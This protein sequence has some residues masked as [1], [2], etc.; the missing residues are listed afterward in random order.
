MTIVGVEFVLGHQ[1]Q[2][3]LLACLTQAG[4][5]R[6]IWDLTR[7]E[8]VDPLLKGHLRPA[9]EV[10]DLQDEIFRIELTDGLNLE[11]LLLEGRQRQY[12]AIVDATKLR[13]PMVDN[14]G[15]VA[16]VE[17]YNVDAIHL[18]DVLV[19]LP[20]VDVLGNEL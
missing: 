18:L 14:V 6:I 1:C 19:A 5:I 16:Q 8:E 13:L 2:L 3:H 4:S 9:V 20:A 15:A 12:L 7:R 17:V 10:V 11:L